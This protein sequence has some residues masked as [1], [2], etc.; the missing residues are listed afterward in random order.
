MGTLKLPEKCAQSKSC[1]KPEKNPEGYAACDIETHEQSA[2]GFG[3][4]S[5]IPQEQ[6]QANGEEMPPTAIPGTPHT[7]GAVGLGEAH[8][9]PEHRRWVA[10]GPGESAGPAHL[11]PPLRM[12]P[13]PL[14][15]THCEACGI[16]RQE[17]GKCLLN[18][19]TYDTCDI[20]FIKATCCDW[21][22]K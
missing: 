4:R 8:P 19:H 2:V 16:D 13:R 14:W 10:G 7:P 5:E 20:Q 15:S 6:V 17:H 12:W 1:K 9:E 11:A 22:A 3:D 21:G 18:K